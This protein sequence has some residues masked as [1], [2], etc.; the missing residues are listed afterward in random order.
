MIE[1]IK[2]GRTHFVELTTTLEPGVWNLSVTK[3]QRG[4]TARS[5]L[6]K[7]S[8]VIGRA[9]ADAEGGAGE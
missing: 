8:D 2:L 3:R 4:Y 7:L 1:L 5:Y 6:G 9:V